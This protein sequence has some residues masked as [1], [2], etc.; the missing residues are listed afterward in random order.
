[1]SVASPIFLRTYLLSF[2]SAHRDIAP[3][4][5]SFVS[6]FGI[7][8]GWHNY[9]HTFPWDYRAAEYGQHYNLTT[10]IIDY[11]AEKGWVYDIKAASSNLVKNHSIK[12]GDGTHPVYGKFTPDDW[13]DSYWIGNWSTCTSSSFSKRTLLQCQLVSWN[14][15][16]RLNHVKNCLNK[17]DIEISQIR[18]ILMLYLQLR[19]GKI[20][21]IQKI[22]IK[23][24]DCS[25][26][27][28]LYFAGK[29]HLAWE[30]SHSVQRLYNCRSPEC[31]F[32]EPWTDVS[33]SPQTLALL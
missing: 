8:E 18:S 14:N 30:K 32:Y 10:T 3:A 1:M 26:E 6:F 20:K 21:I 4:E 11:C 23:W 13:I 2:F 17:Y 29:S 15:Y 9:H 31:I 5:N 22:N 25:S 7:G 28:N 16:K 24:C 19:V 33:V 12:K 27:E